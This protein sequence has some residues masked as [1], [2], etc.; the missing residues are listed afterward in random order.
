MTDI[1]P[2]A[3]PEPIPDQ[4][5]RDWPARIA[6]YAYSLVRP[7]QQRDLDQAPPPAGPALPGIYPRFTREPVDRA[8]E[9]ETAGY[10]WPCPCCGSVATW[11]PKRPGVGDGTEYV[12]ACGGC[13]ERG[14]CGEAA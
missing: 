6:S 13:D 7:P 4:P 5:S 2:I 14:C 10:R 9:P 3:A 1:R 8:P 12:I 11:L